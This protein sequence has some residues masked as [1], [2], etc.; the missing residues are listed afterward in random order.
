MFREKYPL[1]IDSRIKN[2]IE[3]LDKEIQEGNEN[4]TMTQH[5]L[6]RLEE[7]KLLQGLFNPFGASFNGK[8]QNPW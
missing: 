7:A 6:Y 3:K 4:G 8:Y 5:K 1:V 2:N